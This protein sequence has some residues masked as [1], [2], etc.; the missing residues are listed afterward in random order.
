MLEEA[1][2]ANDRARTVV[3]R[4]GVLDSDFGRRVENAARR[5]FGSVSD[6]RRNKFE[7]CVND[8]FGRR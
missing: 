4:G 7:I 6:K 2:A 3:R 1:W 8:V 5:F